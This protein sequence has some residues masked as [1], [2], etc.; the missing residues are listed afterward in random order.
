MPS[1]SFFRSL[2]LYVHES[3]FNPEL[4]TQLQAQ[5]SQSGS[6]KA[7][8]TQPDD[9]GDTLDEDIRKVL[10]VSS[11]SSMEKMVWDAIWDLKPRLEDHF[12][13]Q[14]RASEYPAFLKYEKG[15]FYRP[16]K[17]GSPNSTAT[18]NRSVSVVIFLNDWSKEPSE[19]TYGGGELTFYGL[20]E[21]PQ[22]EN[23][24]FPLQPAKGLLVAFRSDI[25]HEVRPVTFG[26]RFTIVNWF[27]V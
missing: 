2:G 14:L 17:D 22:W 24:P 10:S 15:A 16:H 3:F 12:H 8:I 1:L 18:K 5:M 11:S 26:Q 25:S 21:G 7:L 27:V 13:V 23:C 9:L 20:L 6:Q 4:C 19:N